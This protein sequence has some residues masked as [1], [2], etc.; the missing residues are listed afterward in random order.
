MFT[1]HVSGKTKKRYIPYLSTFQTLYDE[2]HCVNDTALY[3]Y[4]YTWHRIEKYHLVAELP[5][6]CRDIYWRTPPEHYDIWKQDQCIRV[7]FGCGNEL[8][9]YVRNPDTRIQTILDST[10]K[11]ALSKGLMCGNTMFDKETNVRLDLSQLL[12]DIYTVKF[13][14]K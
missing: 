4:S 2:L 7:S 13:C 1:I 10:R 11:W 3:F 6:Y 8:T 9:W 5:A 14:I 12:L